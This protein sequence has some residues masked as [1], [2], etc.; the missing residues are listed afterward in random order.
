M[1]FKKNIEPCCSYCKHGNIISDTEV[2]CIKKGIVTSA[3]ACRKFSYDPLK[4]QPPNMAV[5]KPTTLS[6]EDF[7]L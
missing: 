5:Y 3:G 7:S 4:R 6:E 2:I 1:L